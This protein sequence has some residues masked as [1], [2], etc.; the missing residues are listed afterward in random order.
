MQTAHVPGLQNQPVST[1]IAT[2]NTDSAIYS[3]SRS[4]YFVRQGEKAGDAAAPVP[5]I[6]T[7]AHPGL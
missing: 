3:P 5:A 6:H 7:R 1:F 4:T 2:K